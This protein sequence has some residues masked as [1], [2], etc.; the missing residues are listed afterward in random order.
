MCYVLRAQPAG[1]TSPQEL[2]G[3][4]LAGPTSPQELKGLC[5]LW[6]MQFSVLERRSGYVTLPR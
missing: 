6:L 5:L 4:C 2:K 1:P 3:L